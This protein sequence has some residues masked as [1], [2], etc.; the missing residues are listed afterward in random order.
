MTTPAETYELDLLFPAM[1]PG[2][3][4]FFEVN[5]YVVV[6]NTLTQDEVSRI[7]E[8]LMALKHQ[9]E[10]SDN[11]T[12]HRINGCYLYEHKPPN[13]TALAPLPEAHPALFEYLTHPRMV[14]LA[15]EAMG[16]KVRL[17]ESGCII[18]RRDPEEDSNQPFRFSF[19][20]GGQP[21]FDSYI[22]DD[23]YHCTF[24]KTLTNL[25][26]LGPDDGGTTVVAGSHKLN[27]PEDEIVV[28]AY[29]EPSLIHQVQAPAGS[30]MLMCETL[31]HATGQIRSDRERV[32]VIGGY[33][34]PKQQ[35]L[36]SPS[37]DFVETVPEHLRSLVAGRPFWTWP[38]R[39]RRLGTAAGSQND[40]P[41]KARMWSVKHGD[42]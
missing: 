24:L 17:E 32:M 20:R 16:G 8:A 30:T 37:F 36:W 9:F 13:F 15:E 27:C 41:Y 10:T 5:G 3:R 33:S 12:E 38:E 18:N 22:Y 42:K 6:E 39:H 21:G 26:D 11:P 28:A 25:T 19:H 23:L 31:I 1:T 34:H 29:E 7:R 2:Q 40:L 4:L 35:A 14:G